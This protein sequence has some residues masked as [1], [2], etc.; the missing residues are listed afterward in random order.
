MTNNP[1]TDAELDKWE[2]IEKAATPAPWCT[3]INVGEIGLDGLFAG[4]ESIAVQD[5]W[6]YAHLGADNDGVDTLNCIAEMRNAFPRLIA[7]NRKLRA[8]II[9]TAGE[10]ALKELFDD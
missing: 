3:A 6:G 1:I 5:R 8:H 9:D 4:N 10:D 7:E 2:R